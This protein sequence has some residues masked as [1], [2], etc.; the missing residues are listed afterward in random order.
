M[1]LVHEIPRPVLDSG[2]DEIDLDLMAFAT[3]GENKTYT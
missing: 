2:E 1:D 3:F